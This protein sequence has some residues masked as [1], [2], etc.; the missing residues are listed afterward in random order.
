M[1]CVKSLAVLIPAFSAAACSFNKAISV[2]NFVASVAAEVPA[3]PVPAE[4]Y[5]SAISAM[6]KGTFHH[7]GSTV[8]TCEE[9]A[10]LGV[11]EA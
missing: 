7:D 6:T 9:V 3:F 11:F 1:P 5:V 10:A 4:K 8:T 2:P